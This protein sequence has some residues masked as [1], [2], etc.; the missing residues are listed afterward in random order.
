MI[1]TI[2]HP[3]YVYLTSSI[4]VNGTDDNRGASFATEL[5]AKA[6]PMLEGSL[7]LAQ[8]SKKLLSNDNIGVK[9]LDFYEVKNVGGIRASRAYRGYLSAK[10]RI[11]V[12]QLARPQIQLNLFCSNAQ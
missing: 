10:P 8:P 7:A 1:S 9:Q 11:S 3:Y 12:Q 4:W 6:S 2:I 5:P